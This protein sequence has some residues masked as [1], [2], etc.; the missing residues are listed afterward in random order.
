MFILTLATI[1]SAQASEYHVSKKWDY[2]EV[3]VTVCADADF[4][5]SEVESAISFWKK[6][7]HP[8]HKNLSSHVTMAKKGDKYCTQGWKYGHILI[9]GPRDMDTEVYNGR[10]FYWY[11]HSNDN[12]VSAFIKIDDASYK[13]NNI[14][15]HEIGHSIGLDHDY[16]DE[17]N[18]MFHEG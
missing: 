8:G 12:L 4:S 3:K 13:K 5:K 7:K 10:C 2:K 16:N 6:E 17:E 18:V 9:A 1:L 14:L 11:N 15:I